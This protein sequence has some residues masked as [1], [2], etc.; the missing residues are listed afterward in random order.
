MFDKYYIVGNVRE[1]FASK[2]KYSAKI[3]NDHPS[4]ESIN[5]TVKKL[6]EL[7]FD[8]E[9]FGGVNELISAYYK[10]QKFPNT[11]F[12]NF[13]DGLSHT[14]R[15]AQS[16]VLL[17]LLD[18][19]FAGSD[20]ISRLIAGNKMYAKTCL[21]KWILTPKAFL[22]FD[23][24]D[25]PNNLDY[26]VVIKPN[27]EGSSLGI[28]KHSLCNCRADVLD[29]L[30]ENIPQYK[31][32]II[33]KY[34]AGYEI[35]CFLIANKYHCYLNEPL[36]CEYNGERYFNDFL[37]GIK[38][39]STHLR[40]ERLAKHVLD[41]SVV[42]KIKKTSYSIFKLFNMNDF[43]RVDFRLKQDGSLYFLEING[44]PV[45]SKTS[46]IGTISNNINISYGEIVSYI[47]K[48]ACQRFS[49]E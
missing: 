21:P 4:Y 42:E 29:Y 17:E 44:N 49:H 48:S 47:I 36:I 9:Y 33:E 7:G 15:K 1:E 23:E 38:E 32:L 20:A 19:P 2:S 34:I 13:C 6:C 25:V 16:A 41:K 3:Y 22:V 37:F 35:T 30:K 28:T 11:L 5:Y 40:T 46:E 45:I 31:E 39:K 8:T 27:R 26:P 18:V 14:N 43:A 24:S 12:L 10:K